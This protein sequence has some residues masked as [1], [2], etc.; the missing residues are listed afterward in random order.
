MLHGSPEIVTL[1][2]DLHEHLVDMQ[3]PV[4]ERP[5]PIDPLALDRDREIRPKSQPPKPDR[6]VA[7]VDPAF[8][9]EIL[10]TPGRKKEADILV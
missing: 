8:T 5:H 4:R 10:N 7:D 9:E 2:I 1:T 6:L 3:P